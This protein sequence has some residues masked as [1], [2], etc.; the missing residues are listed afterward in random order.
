[1]IRISNYF[2]GL[3]VLWPFSL[4]FQDWDEN[5]STKQ[6]EEL[7]VIYDLQRPSRGAATLSPTKITQQE[8]LFAIFYRKLRLWFFW[9]KVRSCK[10]CI[11][12]IEK[13]FFVKMTVLDF[14]S[15][16]RWWVPLQNETKRLFSFKNVLRLKAVFYFRLFNFRGY[17]A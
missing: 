17:T 13:L 14:S 4:S 16:E 10:S 12:H 7:L 9:P 6:E 8:V 11:L 5:D 2:V 15:A 1:M 3:F